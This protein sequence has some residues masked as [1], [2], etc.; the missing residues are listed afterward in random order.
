MAQLTNTMVINT[1]PVIIVTRP[2]ITNQPA[3]LT[4]GPGSS[5]TFAVGASGT[6]PLIYQWNFQ[7]TPISGA[8]MAAY[9]VPVAQAANGGAYSVTVSNSAGSV[10]SSNAWLT[11]LSLG[12]WG[13][14]ALNQ[15]NFGPDPTNL[16]AVAAGGWHSLGLRPDGQ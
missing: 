9:T 1:N 10:L 2:T 5:A 16:V 15:I 13:D 6:A 11:V 7:G 12:G 3:G 8:T 14:D 4:V